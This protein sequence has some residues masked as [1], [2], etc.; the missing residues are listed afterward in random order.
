MN[1]ELVLCVLRG[2]HS[3]INHQRNRK[4]IQI[5]SKTLSTFCLIWPLFKGLKFANTSSWL[6]YE[7]REILSYREKKQHNESGTLPVKLANSQLNVRSAGKPVRSSSEFPLIWIRRVAC[8]LSLPVSGRYHTLSVL[9]FKQSRNTE[10]C[11]RCRVSTYRRTCYGFHENGARIF[12]RTA[13]ETLKTLRFD[14]KTLVKCAGESPWSMAALFCLPGPRSIGGAA[15]GVAHRAIGSYKNASKHSQVQQ[16][17]T[18]YPIKSLAASPLPNTSHLN[19][20]TF[21][22]S[23]FI[24]LT[25]PRTNFSFCP[26]LLRFFVM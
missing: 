20:G 16:S 13:T 5:Y 18:C 6:C 24:L 21:T 15:A 9:A 11:N 10:W 7:L 3:C 2:Y 26:L 12:P 19:E 25:D 17:P 22:R 4:W 14:C 23:N 8:G 1:L